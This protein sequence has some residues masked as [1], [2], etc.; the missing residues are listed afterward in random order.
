MS[1][2]LELEAPASVLQSS[3]FFQG[4]MTK[5]LC[6]RDPATSSKVLREMLRVPVVKQ[7]LKRS[8]GQSLSRTSVVA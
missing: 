6:F 1:D 7:Q 8:L 2:T 3:I 5:A 4:N